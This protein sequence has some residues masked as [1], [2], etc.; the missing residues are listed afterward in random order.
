MGV[1]INAHSTRAYPFI[2]S[3]HITWITS[4]S[5]FRPSQRH[6]TTYC[7][8]TL[9]Y[10]QNLLKCAGGGRKLSGYHQQTP[11][12][13]CLCCPEWFGHV[14]CTQNYSVFSRASS[15]FTNTWKEK[16]M[17][18]FVCKRRVYEC[19]NTP[20]ARSY[21]HP[22]LPWYPLSDDLPSGCV[23]KSMC[24]PIC[25][26][27]RWR[28]CVSACVCVLEGA[29][30]LSSKNERKSYTTVVLIFPLIY[31]TDYQALTE[32]AWYKLFPFPFTRMHICTHKTHVAFTSAL[33][34]LLG[35]P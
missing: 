10:Q 35:F 22:G 19:L 9:T 5:F 33:S 24:V 8:W 26:S 18:R 31:V 14:W 28:L 17:C 16:K 7:A 25:E 3:A 20:L 6:S 12:A 15:N 29:R 21:G 32:S 23:C 11:G 34:E 2:L 27:V 13:D 30:W 4:T 1:D